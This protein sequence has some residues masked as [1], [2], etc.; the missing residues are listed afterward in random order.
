M[1][2]NALLMYVKK[3]R[4]FSQ[5]DDSLLENLIIVFLCWFFTNAKIVIITIFPITFLL[6]THRNALRNSLR[7]IEED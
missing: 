4:R 5:T 2:R 1:L 6:K 3:S 7:R